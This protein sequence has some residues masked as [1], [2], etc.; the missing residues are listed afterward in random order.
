MSKPSLAPVAHP[1]QVPTRLLPKSHIGHYVSDLQQHMLQAAQT[2]AQP[3]EKS[4]LIGSETQNSR[5][6]SAL[7]S[8]REA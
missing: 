2:R 8:M 7:Y 1:R 4:A 3:Q 6:L 5:L